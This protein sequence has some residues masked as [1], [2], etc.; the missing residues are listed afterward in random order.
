MSGVYIALYNC[1][2]LQNPKPDPFCLRQTVFHK[3]RTDMK[4]SAFCS[5]RITGIADMTAS[6]DIVRMQDIESHDPTI[7]FSNA[8][9][10]LRSKKRC[11][12]HFIQQILLRERDPLI[13]NIVPDGYDL[14]QV[15][16][17]IFSY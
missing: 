15:L 3:L 8:R 4:P 7:M 9:I 12:T 17:P 16:L 11:P 13:H 2:K 6:S 5:Y 14:R 1:V 10:T